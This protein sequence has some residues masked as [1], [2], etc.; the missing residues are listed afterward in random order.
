MTERNMRTLALERFVGAILKGEE[1][2]ASVLIVFTD[3]D[4]EAINLPRVDPL[5]IKLRI[6]NAIVSRV[7]V[8]GE[9]SIDTIF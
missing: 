4:L 5:I 9:N 2:G 6:G 1:V 3:E 7:L 8:D